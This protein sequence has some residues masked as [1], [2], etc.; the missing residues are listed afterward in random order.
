MS[1]IRICDRC[2]RR[3]GIFDKP[4]TFCTW[5]YGRTPLVE[6]QM[7]RRYDLC[8]DRYGQ[9]VMFMHVPKSTTVY[10]VEEERKSFWKRKC[11]Q[12][13]G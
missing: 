11:E 10:N 4:W 9:F 1:E 12:D 7:Y 13:D 5:R 8:E 6:D 2:G 3:Q